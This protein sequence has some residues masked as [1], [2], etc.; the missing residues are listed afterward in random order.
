MISQ[1]AQPGGEAPHLKDKKITF[2]IINSFKLISNDPRPAHVSHPRV[3]GFPDEY[4]LMY[5]SI[6]NQHCCSNGCGG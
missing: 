6:L 3:K 2:G 4:K 1:V 5:T